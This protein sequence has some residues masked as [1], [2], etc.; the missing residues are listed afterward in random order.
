MLQSKY[1]KCH[2]ARLSQKSIGIG[3]YEITREKTGQRILADYALNMPANLE[4]SAV[5]TAL[6]KSQFSFQ[7]QNRS[8]PKNVQT[9]IQLHSFH[10][11]ARSYSKSFKLGFNQGQGQGQAL[12]VLEPRTFTCT[13][14]IQKMQRNQRSNCQHLLDHRKIKG[15]PKIKST[16][17]SLTMQKLLTVW[18]TTNCGK[19]LKRDT[20]PPYLPPEKPVYRTRSNSQNETWNN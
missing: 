3:K 15:I 12:T 5:A 13:L 2:K 19:F 1:E 17:A 4:N 20:R 6:E 11:L 7:S 8:M 10:M 16:S 14:W 9:T 18:I